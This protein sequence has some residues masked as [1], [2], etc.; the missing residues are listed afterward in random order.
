MTFI[1]GSQT[2]LE[3][4]SLLARVN[5]DTQGTAVR[6]VDVALVNDALDSLVVLFDYFSATASPD[7]TIAD[8]LVDIS[9]PRHVLFTLV[10]GT[11]NVFI[12]GRQVIAN[13]PI[14]E[15][16]GSFGIAL[17]GRGAGARCEGR[18]I[19]VYQLP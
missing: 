7:V 6:Y 15:S 9:R 5:T 17:R 4:C 18:N 3:Q 13:Q 10:D 14:T 8:V 19:W 12:D 2:D 16:A 11:A 1:T